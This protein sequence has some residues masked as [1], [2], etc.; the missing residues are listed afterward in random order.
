MQVG[1]SPLYI[2]DKK[3]GK[4]GFGQV[5]LGRR[6]QPTKEKDGANAN[7]VRSARWR[8]VHANAVHE[9]H[10]PQPS[11]QLAQLLGLAACRWHSS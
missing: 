9:K 8:A 11:L 3:L 5:Y 1:G 6:Q 2:V 7:L 10:R 4:G